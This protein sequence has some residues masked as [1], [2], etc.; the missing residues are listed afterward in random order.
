[1]V[2]A[3]ARNVASAEWDKA[4][5][6]ISSN[7]GF[8]GTTSGTQF[9][10]ADDPS[11]PIAVSYDY[12]RH[13]YAQQGRQVQEVGFPTRN[14]VEGGR[15]PVCTSAARKI[16]VP[17]VARQGRSPSAGLVSFGSARSASM[18]CICFRE[19][20]AERNGPQRR[21]AEGGSLIAGWMQGG[22]FLFQ[23]CVLCGIMGDIMSL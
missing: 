17:V 1:L 5:Q 12:T 9:T 21:V 7:T 22:D 8:S 18:D 16:G 13:P 23:N 14:E 6:Y 3:L 2:R 20:V 10:N 4:S 15:R 19:G 11:A